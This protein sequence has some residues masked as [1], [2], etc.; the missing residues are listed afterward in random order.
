MRMQQLVQQLVDREVR[1]RRV[2]DALQRLAAS[3]R[4]ARR[5]RALALLLVQPRVVDGERGAVGGELEQVALV[6]R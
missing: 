4:C 5:A 6:G 2:G 1:E 3:P